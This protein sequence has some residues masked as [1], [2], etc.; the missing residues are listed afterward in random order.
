M[1]TLSLPTA[2]AGAEERPEIRPPSLVRASGT[3]C[4]ER[5]RG[6]WEQGAWERGG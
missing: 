3:I 6:T 4:E 2:V 1:T 5:E